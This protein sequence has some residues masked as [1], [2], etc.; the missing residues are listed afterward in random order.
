MN[1]SRIP[2][3]TVSVFSR[4]CNCLWDTNPQGTRTLNCCNCSIP[5]WPAK[6]SKV[7]PHSWTDTYF[8]KEGADRQAKSLIPSHGSYP[9]SCWISCAASPQGLS[10]VQDCGT[11]ELGWFCCTGS[12]SCP[13]RYRWM[14]WCLICLCFHS[15]WA[16]GCLTVHLCL[17][18]RSCWCKIPYSISYSLWCNLRS[19]WISWCPST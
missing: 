1:I 11:C 3:P 14:R 17:E 8:A 19:L 18:K 9:F 15:R 6:E 7:P 10:V 5:S 13:L 12:V 4:D 16:E 2:C